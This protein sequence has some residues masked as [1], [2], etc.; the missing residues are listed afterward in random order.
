MVTAAVA[1]KA[2]ELADE[3][4]VAVVLLHYAALSPVSGPLWHRCGYRPVL[5]GW[6]RRP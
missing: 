3:A 6:L 1:A 2:H 5:T 4:G